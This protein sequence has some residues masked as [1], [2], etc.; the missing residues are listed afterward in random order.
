M[1]EYG[2]IPPYGEETV[3][4]HLGPGLKDTKAGEMMAK[5]I[6][7]MKSF[8]SQTVEKLAAGD[9]D[10]SS[11]IEA[12]E[13]L[14][15]KDRFLIPKKQGVA[16]DISVI[17]ACLYS[18]SNPIVD[19][20]LRDARVQ[21]HFLD[22]NDQI[23]TRLLVA[24]P[25]KVEIVP[26]QEPSKEEPSKRNILLEEEPPKTTWAIIHAKDGTPI[27]IGSVVNCT[28]DFVVINT[29]TGAQMTM[30]MAC[31]TLI[32]SEAELEAFKAKLVNKDAKSG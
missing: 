3:K 4:V 7:D 31:L 6:E 24:N 32:H 30:P 15:K 9:P 21:G 19:A 12:I 16:R 28:A 20:I 13:I 27:A 5:Q 11:R 17:Y 25:V 23:E 18:L 2:T 10:I 29:G 14:G 26:V 22:K 1:P 8:M